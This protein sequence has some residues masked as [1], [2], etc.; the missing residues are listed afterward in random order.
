MVRYKRSGYGREPLVVVLISHEYHNQL[1][2]FITHST[3]DNDHSAI[4]K[5]LYDMVT[6]TTRNKIKQLT[7]T[8]EGHLAFERLKA[9]VNVCPKLYFIDYALRII[10][11]TDSSEYAHGAYLCQLRPLP[12]EGVVEEP[13]RFLEGIFYGPQTRWSTIEK[14]AYAIFYALRK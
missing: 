6:V 8:N 13:I 9:L 3:N 11:Y 5:P 14:E 1:T 4:A 12:N 7:W 2:L 10:L